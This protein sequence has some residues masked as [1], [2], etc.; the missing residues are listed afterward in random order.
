MLGVLLTLSS[1]LY[2]IPLSVIIQI[3]IIEDSDLSLD[4]LYDHVEKRQLG[5]LTFTN[6]R[7]LQDFSGS[8][9]VLISH[10]KH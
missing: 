5:H 6:K 10:G 1:R 2:V 3:V 9:R 8:H 7:S 4:L